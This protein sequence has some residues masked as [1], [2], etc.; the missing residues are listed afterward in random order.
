MCRSPTSVCALRSH[1]W[2]GGSTLPELLFAEAQA[3]LRAYAPLASIALLRLAC[4]YRSYRTPFRHG[5]LSGGTMATLT[6][7]AYLWTFPR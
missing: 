1:S 4:L 7:P 3:M 2:A 6:T 5:S